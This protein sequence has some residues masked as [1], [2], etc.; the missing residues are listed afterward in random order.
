MSNSMIHLWLSLSAVPSFLLLLFSKN[1]QASKLFLY[2]IYSCF[3][4]TSCFFIFRSGGLDFTVYKELYDG[5]RVASWDLGYQLI[6]RYFRRVTTLQFEY[7]LVFQ[8][9]L[10]V[11]IYRI[12]CKKFKINF[13][14]FF[15]IYFVHFYVIRDL[16]QFRIGLAVSIFLVSFVSKSRLAI[17]FLVITAALVHLTSIYLLPVLVFYRYGYKSPLVY[18]FIIFFLTIFT[19]Q[20]LLFLSEFFPRIGHYMR[21]Q[22]DGYGAPVSNY[23]SMALYAYMIIISLNINSDYKNKFYFTCIFSLLFSIITFFIFSNMQIFAYRLSSIAASL[24][25]FFLIY[26]FSYYSGS[27]NNVNKYMFAITFAILIAVLA[28]RSGN[29]YVLSNIVTFYE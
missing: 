17:I 13:Y 26:I 18:A 28:A 4:I 3:F 11:A 9:F 10:Q 12:V 1:T 16:S 2:L 23:S 29:S 8:F 20:S 27:R 24:Y 19:S 22:A 5:S 15:I 14:L 7:F 25:P 6:T 21:W